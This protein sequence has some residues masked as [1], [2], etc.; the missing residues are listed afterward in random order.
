MQHRLHIAEHGGLRSH[1][2]LVPTLQHI[3][4]AAAPVRRRPRRERR[5]GLWHP[6]LLL[7]CVGLLLLQVLLLRRNGLCLHLSVSVYLHPNS[8][9]QL[10]N[11]IVSHT[12][13]KDP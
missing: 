1:H 4:V 10:T 12:A 11:T 8:I 13:S 9:S 6:A 2:S 7:L 5:P 3:R